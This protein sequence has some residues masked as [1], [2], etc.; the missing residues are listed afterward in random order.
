MYQMAEEYTYLLGYNFYINSDTIDRS[1]YFDPPLPIYTP[2]NNWSIDL[3]M[4]I[5]ENGQVWEENARWEGSGQ[6]ADPIDGQMLELNPYEVRVSSDFGEQWGW[7]ISD[8]NAI[9]AQWVEFAHGSGWTAIG[10]I[11]AITPG[12]PYDF[13]LRE[14]IA[15]IERVVEE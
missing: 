8:T 12:F 15:W 6:W 13:P 5:E 11:I 10:E 7:Q 3:V 9:S 14:G 2:H 4:T 1:V